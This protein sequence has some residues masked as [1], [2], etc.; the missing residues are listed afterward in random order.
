MIT[1]TIKVKNSERS[2]EYPKETQLYEKWIVVTSVQYPTNDMK[3]L[4]KLP[5]WKLVMVGDL[6]TPADW[7]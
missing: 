4:S 6:K 2:R 7:Q 5:G 3:K 1:F